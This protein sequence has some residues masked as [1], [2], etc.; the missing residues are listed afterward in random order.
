MWWGGSKSR[1]LN[2]IKAD[3]LEIQVQTCETGETALIGSAAVAGAAVGLLKDY[4]EDKVCNC[5][6]RLLYSRTT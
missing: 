5:R 4:K 3:V 6:E 2:Q 1:L